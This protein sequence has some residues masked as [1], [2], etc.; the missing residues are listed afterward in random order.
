M[1]QLATSMKQK[2]LEIVN[3]YE[4]NLNGSLTKVNLNILPLGSYDVLIGT[5]WL[6]QHHLMLNFLHNSI[7]CTDNQ[8]N[9]VK[10]QGIPKKFSIRQISALQENKCIRKGCKLFAVNVQNIEAK[11]EQHIEDFPVLV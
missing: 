3:Y 4:I 8:E 10:I 6:K 5:N 9:Q 7:F 11:R 1:V 2:V